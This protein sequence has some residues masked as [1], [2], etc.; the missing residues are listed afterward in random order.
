MKKNKVGRPP[1][2][3]NEEAMVS[4]ESILD[5]IP[6]EEIIKFLDPKRAAEEVGKVGKNSRNIK[7]VFGRIEAKKVTNL[8]QSCPTCGRI[9]YVEIDGQIDI[10]F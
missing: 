2:V 4:I 3:K 9:D 1:K 8:G 10:T 6:R 7:D 5:D